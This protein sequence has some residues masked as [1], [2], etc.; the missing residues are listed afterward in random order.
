M[1]EGVLIN[2]QL[3]DYSKWLTKDRLLAENAA[4]E[5]DR[6]FEKYAAAAVLI[7]PNV[8]LEVGCGAGL[9]PREM[10]RL[11]W[12]GFY[13]GMDANLGCLRLAH[14]NNPGLPF[15]YDDIRTFS[16]NGQ[17]DLV[18]CFAVLKHFGLHEWDAVFEK[19]LSLG[20]NVLFTMSLAEKDFDAGDEFHITS[21]TVDHLTSAVERY[22]HEGVT[23]QVIAVD[24]R[25]WEEHLIWT[26][27][28][29]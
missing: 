16:W 18:C 21:V 27:R 4:W 1:A 25:G 23:N 9:I 11:N 22:G 15:V 2:R 8:V 28:G 5:Q 12:P 20:Q 29:S 24:D 13:F 19:V 26:T 7:Q 17:A 6:Y 3:D 14:H 10:K